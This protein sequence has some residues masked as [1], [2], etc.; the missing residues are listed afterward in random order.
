MAIHATGPR[1]PTAK[2]ESITRIVTMAEIVDATGREAHV[3]PE[4]LSDVLDGNTQRKR[5]YLVINDY[6]WT[7]IL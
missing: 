6:K 1:P 2:D 3:P 7:N 5:R 4:A